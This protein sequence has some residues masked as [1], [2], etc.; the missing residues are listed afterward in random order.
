LFSLSSAPSRIT[1]PPPIR[2]SRHPHPFPPFLKKTNRYYEHV[3]AN[4]R[5]HQE[6][7]RARDEQYVKLQDDYRGLHDLMQRINKEHGDQDSAFDEERRK[8]ESKVLSVQ[9]RLDT[10]ETAAQ[11]AA[12]KAKLEN[13]ELQQDVSAL[14]RELILRTER[15]V[16]NLA[17]MRGAVAQVGRAG[18]SQSRKIQNVKDDVQTFRD[19][20]AGVSRELADS[21]VANHRIMHMGTSRLVTMVESL[22]SSVSEHAEQVGVLRLQLEEERTRTIMLDEER[23][24]LSHD[25]SAVRNRLDEAKVRVEG[26]T[27]AVACW[28]VCFLPPSQIMI[29]FDELF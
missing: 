28:P 3:A 26:K 16:E 27:G 19:S 12:A 4:T 23:S 15:Y 1:P 14:Q 2:T 7:L 10:S 25:N 11:E 5:E 22:R 9:A 17:A 6:Q 18:A 24:R 21:H 8:Y 13:T 20:C 29:C